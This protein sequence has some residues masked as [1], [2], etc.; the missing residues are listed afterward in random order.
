MRNRRYWTF[1][2]PPRPEVLCSDSRHRRCMKKGYC[3][4]VAQII[5]SDKKIRRDILTNYEKCKKKYANLHCSAFRIV[6]EAQAFSAQELK[7]LKMAVCHA[8]NWTD[9]VR[10]ANLKS[11]YIQKDMQHER[12]IYLLLHNRIGHIFQDMHREAR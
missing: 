12:K 3:Q 11:R 2:R 4:L 10:E 5:K 7:R 6:P 1:H 8:M 9:E